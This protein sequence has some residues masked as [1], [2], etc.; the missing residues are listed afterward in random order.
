MKTLEM[1][2][3]APVEVV[4]EECA[5]ARFHAD[6]LEIRFKGKNVYEVLDMTVEQAA[7]FFAD[8]PKISRGLT[9]LMDVGLGYLRLGQPSTTLSGGEAQRVKL[10]TELQ[11]PATGKTLYILDEPTTGLH[12]QDVSRLLDALQRLVDAGNSVVV[13]EHN[14]DVVRA[15][16]WLIDL[17][18]EGGVGG[19]RLV[20]EGTPEDVAAVSGSHTGEA[21]RALGLGGKRRRGKQR[22]AAAPASATGDRAR[23]DRR[24]R[25]PNPQLEGV[26]CDVPLG[27]FTV[28]TGPSGS[29][30]SSLAFDTIFQKGSDASS[31]ACRR[32]PA[33]SLD[34]WTRRLSTS[35]MASGRRSRSTRSGRGAARDRPS[36]RPLRSMITCGCS[37]RGSGGTTAQFTV[38]RW[39]VGLRARRPSA[40]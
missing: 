3:L 28:V 13:I 5:G 23:G 29:G 12:F 21:L 7:E 16:D 25:R 9:A 39:R 38:R 6:T 8:L 22:R 34:A 33:G 31:R 30:K 10:A 15:A 32:M 26:D 1:N 40:S 2:F 20:A 36:R 37:T 35:S 19:G 27:E 17:G 24:A 14:L 18:P 11:R 4:C